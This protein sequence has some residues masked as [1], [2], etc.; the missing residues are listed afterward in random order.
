MSC[1][2]FDEIITFQIFNSNFVIQIPKFTESKAKLDADSKKIP[3]SNRCITGHLLNNQELGLQQFGNSPSNATTHK[4]ALWRTG[5]SVQE[6]GQCLCSKFDITGSKEMPKMI[7]FYILGKGNIVNSLKLQVMNFRKTLN[8]ML[9]SFIA[10]LLLRGRRGSSAF[11][12]QA[13]SNCLPYHTRRLVGKQ[14]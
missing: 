12:L 3:H 10:V 1:E 13:L 5:L 6:P 4:T 8:E 9:V 2:T 11:P 7:L 14:F